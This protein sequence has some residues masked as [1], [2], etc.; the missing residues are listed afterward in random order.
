MAKLTVL[1]SNSWI[2]PFAD[3]KKEHNLWRI[4]TEI[5]NELKIKDGTT[6]SIEIKF[7]EKFN[8]SEINQFTIT[9]GK[10]IYFPAVFKRRITGIILKNPK[11]YFIATVKKI[12][13]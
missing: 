1:S 10:E 9:S 6:L 4:P 8:V 7:E 5:V 2:Q 3:R 13:R 11:S 12:K